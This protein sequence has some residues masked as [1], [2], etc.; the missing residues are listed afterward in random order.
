M[1]IRAAIIVVKDWKERAFL[2]AELSE[3]G[4]RTFAVE[5][6][7]EAEEWLADPGVTPIIIIYDTNNQDSPSRDLMRL[8]DLVS[9]IPVLILTS[10]AEKK[11]RNLE[12]LGFKHIIQRPIR[13]GDVVKYVKEILKGTER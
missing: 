6:M 12:E 8:S 13:I 2:R 9:H 4:I 1:K 10:P 11:A 5:I 3:E 7:V